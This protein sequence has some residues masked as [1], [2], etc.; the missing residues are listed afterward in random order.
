MDLAITGA[1]GFLGRALVHNARRAGH[2]VR[3]L[4]LPQESPP[5]LWSE[6]DVHIVRGGLAAVEQAPSLLDGTD[7]LLHLAATGV[8]ARERQWPQ[9]IATNVAAPR[10]WAAEAQ[11][12]GVSHMVAVGT[13]LEYAGFGVLPDTP[14]PESKPTPR[15]DEFSPL[16]AGTTYGATKAAGG[17][18]LRAFAREVGFPLFYLRLASLFGP[19]DDPAK[20]IPSAVRTARSGTGFEMTAGAQVREWLHIDDAVTALLAAAESPPPVR[21]EVLNVGTGHGV[22][23]VDLVHQIFRGAGHDP[24]LVEAGAKPYRQ[25][26]A[27]HLVMQCDRVTDTLGWHPEISLAAGLEQLLQ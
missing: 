5:A 18:I 22:E 19:G 27:H 8:Q 7:V 12:C 10:S 24:S 21:G 3:A 2:T 26:E 14:W 9:M 23:L 15:C 25:H 1:T 11:K 17:V 16:E 13:C 20:L 4:V 6:L